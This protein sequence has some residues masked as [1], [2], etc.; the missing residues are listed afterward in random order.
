MTGKQALR[1]IFWTQAGVNFIGALGPELSFDALWYHLPIARLL[2]ERGWWGVIPGGLLY[3]SGLPRLMEFVNALLLFVGQR[4]GLESPELLP[5]LLS[6][7]I[8][9]ACASMIFK[10]T[11]RFAS[12]TSAWGAVVLWYTTLV[13]GWQTIVVYVDLARTLATLISVWYFLEKDWFR[14]AVFIGCAYAI[15][16]F[17]GVDAVFM[18]LAWYFSY[19]DWKR[20]VKF[21]VV[22][23]GLAGIWGI[24]N[25][26][27][28]YPFF[29][30][31]GSYYSI[32]EH[33]VWNFPRIL[34]P[35]W[36][37]LNPSIRVGPVT[38]IILWLSWKNIRRVGKLRPLIVMVGAL[39][40]SWYI[41][42]R[43]WDGRY[44]LP[45]LSIMGV[46]AMSGL[47]K[48]L[49]KSKYS[50]V[51]GLVILQGLGGVIYRG[52]ANTKFVPYVLGLETKANF[53][54]KKLNFE[55]GDWYDSDGWVKEN[56]ADKQYLVRGVHNIYYLPG[57]LWDHESWADKQKCYPYVLIQGESGVSEGER[58]V[59]SIAETKTRIYETSCF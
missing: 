36:E 19:G 32:S 54:A 48:H 16:N 3:T 45:T 11:R 52:A 1:A 55:F 57:V 31:V 46:L 26:L 27:Q 56:L 43:S 8:G 6:F 9:L 24:A 5:K 17:A 40:L 10:I 13:V 41:V 20:G 37:T 21:F 34:G 38:P 33:V 4:V 50:L 2:A 25:I 15:K 12:E 30:P 29:Y 28:G 53:L 51:M 22:F 18:S 47:D 7:G 14:S 49:N 42:P 39:L 59:H 23:A 58:L 35:I 44:F